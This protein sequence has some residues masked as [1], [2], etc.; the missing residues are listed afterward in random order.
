MRKW[1]LKVFQKVNIAKCFALVLAVLV[2]VGVNGERV[3]AA[4]EWLHEDV[5]YNGNRFFMYKGYFEQV[6]ASD[7]RIKYISYT[8]SD[9]ENVIC[10][11]YMYGNNYQ[12][13]IVNKSNVQV[14][15]SRL[16]YY[17]DGTTSNSVFSIP[18]N[19][20]VGYNLD[21]SFYEYAT[22]TPYVSD[23]NTYKSLCQD[24]CN[25]A[26]FAEM[27]KVRP[28]LDFNSALD[29]SWVWIEDFRASLEDT[30]IYMTWGEFKSTLI[31]AVEELKQYEHR[32][33]GL[34]G[35]FIDERYDED[36]SY[37]DMIVTDVVFEEFEAFEGSITFEDFGVPDGYRLWY[38]HA[39]PFWFWD[40]D[41][42]G[43]LQKGKSS[44]ITFDKDGGS[45]NALI[46]DS[47][48][49]YNP[50]DP[51]FSKWN[52]I[53]NFTGNYFQ[54]MQQTFDNTFQNYDASGMDGNTDKLGE[55]LKNYS[56]GQDD[57]INS[58]SKNIEQFNPGEYLNFT[59]SVLV[60]MGLTSG[61][62][63]QFLDV[64]ADFTTVF[65]VGC[66][67]VVIFVVLG[68]WRFQG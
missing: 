56:D 57:V 17:S 2:L 24:F 14:T 21:P 46:K 13:A 65:I 27:F 64:S 19:S 26:E 68:I 39:Y 67:M 6:C 50:I 18:A 12:I 4:E 47:N 22:S 36:K 54:N 33:I 8:P 59:E 7:S 23:Y 32:Y 44:M 16:F 43:N 15:L 25:S 31:Q 35:I 34:A 28:E 55:G 20:A 5:V 49:I 1:F 3:E 45:S 41:P 11:F 52:A 58:V 10:F 48:D 29:A 62:I 38:L 63:N 51:D 37:N 30:T 61:W 60:A 42:E 40:D 9:Y 53:T 66:V